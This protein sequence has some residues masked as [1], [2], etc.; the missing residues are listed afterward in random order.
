MGLLTR[1]EE[2]RGVNKELIFLAWGKEIFQEG[3]G[4]GALEEFLKI[5]GR[6]GILEAL[7]KG[8][9]FRVGEKKVG[10]ARFW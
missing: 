1:L 5:G 7:S 10:R 9:A 3:L 2:K 4:K 8:T 6:Q